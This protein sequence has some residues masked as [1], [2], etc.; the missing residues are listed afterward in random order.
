MKFEKK[1]LFTIPNIL[2]YI[3]LLCVPV[4]ISML[5]MFKAS[6]NKEA[7]MWAA[8]GIFVFASITDI[9]DGAIARKCNMISDIG[10]LLDPL[11]DKLLQCSAL[12]MLA[13]V[14]N[15]MWVFVGILLAKEIYLVIMT[16]Y[17]LIAGKHQIDQHSNVWGK[18]SAVI[19]FIGIILGF[20]THRHQVI[21]WVTT[22]VFII[23]VGFAIFAAFQYTVKYTMQLSQLRKSGAL[24]NLDS[25]GD[26]IN[27]QSEKQLDQVVDVDNI[28]NNTDDSNYEIINNDTYDS[29]T[30]E[31]VDTNDNVSDDKESDN[32]IQNDK[33]T[34]DNDKKSKV[35]NKKVNKRKD[36]SK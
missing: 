30:G 12:I 13:V 4:F 34:L 10:K 11:A 7:Y 15:V 35:E 22:S 20:S 14:G 9:V 23:G 32:T 5:A 3:R 17:Y 2:T 1:D 28:D 29:N 36:K 19:V 27:S 18:V 31:K 26:V 8:F 33:D 25:R 6:S 24:I 16:Q 21:D